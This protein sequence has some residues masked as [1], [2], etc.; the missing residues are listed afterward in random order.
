MDRVLLW[1]RAVAVGLAKHLA[2][3]HSAAGDEARVAR[4][5]MIA[6]ARADVVRR[7]RTDSR[8]AAELADH[9]HKRRVEQSAIVEIFEQLRRRLIEHGTSPLLEHREIVAVR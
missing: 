9:Q 8:R 6:A 7:R 1:I 4:R 2:W 3:A 5:P